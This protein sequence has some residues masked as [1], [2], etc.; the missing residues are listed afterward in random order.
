[1]GRA[2]A[3][4]APGGGMD[5]LV[6]HSLG[7]Y[8]VQQIIGIGG[9][10]NVYQAYQASLDRLVA[11]K[12]IPTKV[13]NARDPGF[14]ARFT[15]EARVI[16]RLSHPNIVT[17]HDYGEDKVW[18]YLVMEYIAGGTLRDRMVAAEAARRRL[19]LAPTLEL[20][21]QAALG[22][23]H[24]HQ[25]GIIH[26]DVKPGNLLL[27]TEEQL[28][29]SDFGIAAI[30]EASAGYARGNGAGT[31][32]YMA[33]EQG[34]PNGTV[35]TRTDIYSLGVVLFQAVTGQLPFHGDS[36]IGIINQHI[37]A[38]VPRPSQLVPGLPPRVEEI[39]L[40]A[41]EKQPA[42]RYQRAREMADQLRQAAAE[43][44]QA[45]PVRAGAPTV[46]H[47]SN[48]NGRA[49]AP[50]PLPLPVMGVPGQPGTCLRCGAKND[51]RNRF[52]IACGYD[53]SGARARADHYILRDGRPLRCQLVVRSGPLAGRAYVLHQ[54]MTTIGRIAGNDLVI[55][56]GTVS[57]YHARL[58]FKKGQWRV[59]DL[60]SSNGTYVNT[61]RVQ[62]QPVPLNDGDELRLGD[63]TMTFKLVC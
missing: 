46:R 60:H 28:L 24:A 52:C 37:T 19:E 51:P 29:L 6:G 27:R 5:N 30:L 13:T 63:D 33:P 44:Q 34:N 48:H 54:D 21:A 41:L 35:D 36:P 18:A 20:L 16:A 47:N 9:M 15:N 12:A 11:I 58:S 59:E 43:L 25:N 17:V 4:A 1:M 22:L 57:R 39:T 10:A 32:Q 23:D 42:R 45:S 40:R 2:T 50:P 31:P 53:L 7:Q 61:S 26:R 62:E 49:L 14:L 56:D 3:T 8:Q 38:P 55:P